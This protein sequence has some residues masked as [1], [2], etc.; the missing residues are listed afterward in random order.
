[1]PDAPVCP[2]CRHPD[3]SAGA[4]KGGICGNCWMRSLDDPGEHAKWH[5]ADCGEYIDGGERHQIVTEGQLDRYEDG[6]D[7]I[8]YDVTYLCREHYDARMATQQEADH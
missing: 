3:L 6:T 2:I 4:G 7:G 5:C 1:M 8:H